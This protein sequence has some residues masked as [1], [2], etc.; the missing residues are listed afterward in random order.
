V[1]ESFYTPEEFIKEA[2]LMGVS[3]R[4][5]AFPRRLKLGETWV[6]FAHLSACGTRTTIDEEGKE[7]KD[8]IPGVFYA[9]CP[10]RVEKLL[11]E[12]EARPEILEDLQKSNITPVLIPDGDLDH[13]PKTPL[14]ISPEEREQ[15]QNSLLFQQL[16]DKLTRKPPA[17]NVWDTDDTDNTE[18][19]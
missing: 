19:E 18:E 17:P 15:K 6:L 10:Q 1:G 14:K 13:D 9:F 16:R 11:W 3:R 2:A 8:G 12:S 4:I 5:A 7:H